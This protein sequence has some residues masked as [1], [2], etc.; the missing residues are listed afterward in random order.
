MNIM[1]KNYQKLMLIDSGAYPVADHLPRV[2][3]IG[4]LIGLEV[5]VDQGSITPLEKLVT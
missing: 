5:V 1:F 4:Q 3:D 2:N